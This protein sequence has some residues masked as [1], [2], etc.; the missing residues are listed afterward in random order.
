MTKEI[1]RP[2]NTPYCPHCEKKLSASGGTT[3]GKI[4]YWVC[5]GCNYEIEDIPYIESGVAF[6]NTNKS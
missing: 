1:K 2:D 5:W 6:L 4:F 3:D